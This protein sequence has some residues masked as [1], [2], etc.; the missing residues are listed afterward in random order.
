[1]KKMEK[2][3][4]LEKVIL[5]QDSIE[6]LKEM[7]S[8][9]PWDSQE[10]IFIITKQILKEILINFIDTNQSFNVIEDWANI[11]ECREDIGYSNLVLKDIIDELTNPILYGEISKEKIKNIIT[12]LDNSI[13]MNRSPM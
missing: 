7:I 8:M 9:L 11:L 10:D 6:N 3:K 13:E 4:I 1:M 12:I 5:L 2:Y